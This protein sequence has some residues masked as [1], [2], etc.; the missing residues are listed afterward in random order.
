MTTLNLNPVIAG[1]FPNLLT[2]YRLKNGVLETVHFLGG[3]S[4]NVAIEGA[5]FSVDGGAIHQLGVGTITITGSNNQKLVW[6][7]VRNAVSVRD[8]LGRLASG[9]IDENLVE[10][11]S[12]SSAESEET[13]VRDI[14]KGIEF[15]DT[16]L[17]FP[18][19]DTILTRALWK[20]NPSTTGSE[21]FQ[22]EHVDYYSWV[23]AGDKIATIRPRKSMS[24]D[25]DSISIHSP[26][27][28][29]IL[30][31]EFF[32]WGD[33]DKQD[34][35]A[36]GSILLPKGVAPSEGCHVFDDLCR[37]LEENRSNLFHNSE[38]FDPAMSDD[39]VL[40]LLNEQRQRKF[41]TRSFRKDYPELFEDILKRKPALNGRLDGQN[42]SIAPKPVGIRGE[43]TFDTND[44]N[45]KWSEAENAALRRYEIETPFSQDQLRNKW[46]YWLEVSPESMQQQI[47]DDYE[48][49]LALTN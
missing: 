21:N 25:A 40:K 17:V 44:D 16:V 28:G 26:V 11:G 23:E 10:T 1:I 39:R 37:Y 46:R 43:E 36:L 3:R 6:S 2:T 22:E 7:N 32:Q 9:E 35:M 5:D 42:K 18:T 13:P 29:I 41:V 14:P 49:L 30:F 12:A 45:K 19:V 8:K 4:G 15:S 33:W 31:R 48:S 27:S 24:S 47:N 34:D 38:A 20:S